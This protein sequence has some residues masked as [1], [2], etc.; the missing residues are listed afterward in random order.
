VSPGAYDQGVRDLQDRHS[1]DMG[2]VAADIF[3][4]H[5]LSGKNSLA[6]KLIVS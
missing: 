3:S 5:Y 2:K 1:D 4:H 6:V